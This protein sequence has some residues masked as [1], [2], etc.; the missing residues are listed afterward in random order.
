MA[1]MMLTNW[2]GGFGR[3]TNKQ[4]QQN[5]KVLHKEKVKRYLYGAL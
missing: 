1:E 3:A 4:H 5:L 2:T